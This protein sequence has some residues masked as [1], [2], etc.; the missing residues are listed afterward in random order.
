MTAR[1]TLTRISWTEV[2]SDKDNRRALHLAL[3]HFAIVFIT[4]HRFPNSLHVFIIHHYLADVRGEGSPVQ[5]GTSSKETEA[6]STAQSAQGSRQQSD[7][8][9]EAS[10]KKKK[11]P[12]KKSGN[13]RIGRELS[14]VSQ[15]QDPLYVFAG[16]TQR[17]H[18]THQTQWKVG[19]KGI[20]SLC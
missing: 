6:S 17:G 5:E 4:S 15:S 13:K 14:P 3:V 7:N 12:K 9:K 11:K 1:M 20:R 16:T 10:K 18:L 8:E 2:S 19:L